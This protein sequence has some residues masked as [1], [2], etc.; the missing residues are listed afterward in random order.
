MMLV[1]RKRKDE[2][3]LEG[4]G[5][6]V[7]DCIKPGIEKLILIY[8]SIGEIIQHCLGESQQEC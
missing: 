3:Y 7:K 1:L 8:L 4:S 5:K 2:T 6:P